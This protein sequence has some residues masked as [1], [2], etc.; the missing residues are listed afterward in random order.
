[1][2]SLAEAAGKHF[3]RGYILQAL[4]EDIGRRIQGQLS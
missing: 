4:A 1:M 3:G 2:A